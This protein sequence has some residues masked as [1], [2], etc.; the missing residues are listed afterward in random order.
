MNVSCIKRVL[1]VQVTD[2]VTVMYTVTPADHSLATVIL[3]HQ[4]YIQ[5]ASKTPI[6]N[7]GISL[8]I[9]LASVSD[10]GSGVYLTPGSG[11]QDG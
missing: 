11:T 2:E 10:P 3:R 5:T 8:T 6:R 7:G 4:E 9:P 1:C